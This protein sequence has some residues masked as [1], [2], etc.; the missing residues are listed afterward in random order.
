MSVYDLYKPKAFFMKLQQQSRL[1][2]T[3]VKWVFML[4]RP[5]HI[6]GADDSRMRKCD[7][8]GKSFCM[9]Q[10]EPEIISPGAEKRPYQ[11]RDQLELIPQQIKPAVSVA[12]SSSR[13]CPESINNCLWQEVPLSSDRKCHYL[14]QEPERHGPDT[15]VLQAQDPFRLGLDYV[16][17]NVRAH[18]MQKLIG[19]FRVLVKSL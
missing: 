7:V 8:R 5:R 17:T 13:S 16:S 12:P 10:W 1:A 3:L 18:R 19:F 6:Q 4:F 9:N 11:I 15:H 2:A 14:P